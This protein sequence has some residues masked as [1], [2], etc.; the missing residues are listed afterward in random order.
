[1]SEGGEVQC[2]RGA[3]AVPVALLEGFDDSDVVEHDELLRVVEVRG[4]FLRIFWSLARGLY[5]SL[6]KCRR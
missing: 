5:L 4:E 3:L 6:Q 1:M 2:E